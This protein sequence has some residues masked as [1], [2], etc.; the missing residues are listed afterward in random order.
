[1]RAI[2]AIA[3]A[4]VTTATGAALLPPGDDGAPAPRPEM[5]RVVH[6]GKGSGSAAMNGS[7]SYCGSGRAG[8]R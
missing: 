2:G 6:S 3:M 7:G 4:A 1:M 8:V 5:L